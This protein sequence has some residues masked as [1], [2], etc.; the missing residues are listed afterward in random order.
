LHDETN[1]LFNFM[2]RSKLS[3]LSFNG[4]INIFLGGLTRNPLARS[5]ST[6]EI[7]LSMER[8]W[9]RKKHSTTRSLTVWAVRQLQAARKTV[10]PGQRVRFLFTLGKPGV[11][12]LD[13]PDQPDIRCIDVYRYRVLFERA[14]Q[15]VLAPIQQ[16]VTGGMDKECL[17]LFPTK[18]AELLAEGGSQ[19]L[20][21]HNLPPITHFSNAVQGDER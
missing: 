8:V 19:R 9:K 10:Q 14:V 3:E 21:V 15:T 18:K 17:Y 2:S 5:C 20:G 13:V 6:Q 11:R 4:L 16:S 7:M 1:Q 12:A